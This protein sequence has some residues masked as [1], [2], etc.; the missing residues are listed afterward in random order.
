MKYSE[1]KD[2]VTELLQKHYGD[3]A[4]VKISE[5]IKNNDTQLDGV[6]VIRKGSGNIVSP[7]VYLNEIF[8]RYQDGQ[9]KDLCDVARH[10]TDLISKH[11]KEGKS[12]AGIVD[13]IGDWSFVSERI[14]PR[15]ISTKLNLENLKNLVSTPFLDLSVI[16]VIRLSGIDDGND[17]NACIKVTESLF[18]N[19]GISK[20]DLHGKAL[21]NL[22]EKD[23]MS[24]ESMASILMDA[25]LGELGLEELEDACES[26][27]PQMSVMSNKS[28][29]FGASELLNLDKLP[30]AFK[31]RSFYVLPSSVHELILIPDEPD[32]DQE[33]LNSMVKEVNQTSVSAE[34]ILSDHAYYYDHVSGELMLGCA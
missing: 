2:K 12:F 5:C 34:E 9:F 20:E 21:E 14:Y 6:S 8:E 25:G 11:V 18:D 7:V 28:R 24:V 29:L 10:I 30:K 33:H 4:E 17:E 22:L 3:K 23:P 1:F 13:Q 32:M 26:P 19:W 15:L 31:E 27:V 16:Y